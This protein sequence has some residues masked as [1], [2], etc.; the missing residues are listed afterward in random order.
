[1]AAGVMMSRI[2]ETEN[3]TKKS[4]LAIALS[5]PPFFYSEKNIAT[6]IKVYVPDNLKVYHLN[7][8]LVSRQ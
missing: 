7:K 3:L 1:M 6:L 2:T 4:A 5:A 8:S